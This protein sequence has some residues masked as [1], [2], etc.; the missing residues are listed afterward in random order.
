[1][2]AAG[3][4][5]ISQMNAMLMYVGEKHDLA[6]DG[7]ALHRGE[8]LGF[9][10]GL[11]DLRSVYT[12]AVYGGEYD[13]DA[14]LA[15]ALLADTNRSALFGESGRLARL[16]KVLAMKRAS[17]GVPAGQ[18][19]FTVGD[20]LTVADISLATFLDDLLVILPQ[21]GEFPEL[22]LVHEHVFGL[23]G[24]KEYVSSDPAAR[25]Q[26]NGNAMGS[27]NSL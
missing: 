17:K 23:P 4:V 14:K 22:K 10:S 3:D 7:S 12:K 11:D 24:V 20:K 1:M 13:T 9:L 19:V 2:T 16:N 8:V 5:T 18:P 6:G 15:A 26:V 25:K 27:G 21:A